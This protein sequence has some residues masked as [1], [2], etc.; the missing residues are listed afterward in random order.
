M[1]IKLLMLPLLLAAFLIGT[2]LMPANVFAQDLVDCPL[3]GGIGAVDF[4]NAES[5]AKGKK[6]RNLY[7][8]WDRID[9][10]GEYDWFHRVRAIQLSFVWISKNDPANDYGKIVLDPMTIGTEARHHKLMSL[11]EPGFQRHRVDRTFAKNNTFTMYTYH[12]L[13]VPE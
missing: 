6:G 9:E 7:V 11:E 3:S 2:A 8:Q 12:L 5:G 1:K 10:D 4:I 13:C